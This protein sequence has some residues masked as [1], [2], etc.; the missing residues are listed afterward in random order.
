MLWKVEGAARVLRT[1]A[2]RVKVFLQMSEIESD[3]HGEL[4]SPNSFYPGGLLLRE[5]RVVSDLIEGEGKI[6]VF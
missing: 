6:L 5:M 2:S 4:Q 3:F 1:F